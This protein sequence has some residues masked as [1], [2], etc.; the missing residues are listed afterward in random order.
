M[1]CP[2]CKNYIRE[3]DNCC[4]GCG[5]RYIFKISKNKKVSFLKEVNGNIFIPLMRLP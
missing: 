3:K 4:N 1:I 5:K 2:Y